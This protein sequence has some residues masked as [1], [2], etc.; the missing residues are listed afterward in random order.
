MRSKY[1]PTRSLWLTGF[2]RNRASRLSEA[3]TTSC[4]WSFA[5]P[6]SIAVRERKPATPLGANEALTDS[7]KPLRLA[8]SP[9]L[10]VASE[11]GGNFCLCQYVAVYTM[12]FG[13]GHRFDF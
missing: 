12:R 6:F 10:C 7:T 4:A 1:Y 3:L 11:H 9:L 5:F 2:I 13:L 8:K